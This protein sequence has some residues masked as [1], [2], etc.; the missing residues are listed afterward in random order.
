MEKN[1]ANRIPYV[2]IIKFLLILGVVLIHSSLNAYATYPSTQ[3]CCN[4]GPRIVDFISSN[5]CNVCVPCFFFLSGVLFFNGLKDFTSSVYTT[6]LK[7]RIHTLLVPYL[8][9]NLFCA[10]LLMI[11]AWWLHMPGLGIYLS[12]GNINLADFIY[13]F[14]A[15]KASGGYPFAFAF[16]FIRNLL[17][18]CLLSPIAFLLG[19]SKTLTA[20]FILFCLLSATTFYGFQWFVLGTCFTLHRRGR[21]PETNI[22]GIIY[23]S[24]LFWGICIAQNFIFDAK[25]ILYNFLMLVKVP[26]ALYLTF[27]L[28]RYFS[29][30]AQKRLLKCMIAS[31]FMIY[32][33]HQ[34]YSTFVCKFWTKICGC[35]TFLMPIL[36][37]ILTFVTLIVAGCLAYML[38]RKLSPRLLK[39]ITGGRE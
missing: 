26:S 27:C 2:G 4:I 21:L 37:F 1:L 35:D 7:H 11:K 18:F 39:I 15:I 20:L 23:A 29:R 5:V 36:A 32:V 8:L 34:C 16:W 14:W 28:A 3:E 13:G 31:T 33:T 22:Q 30:F 25:S 19:R 10:L 24:L 6:K 17:V 9:W 38:L 12:N